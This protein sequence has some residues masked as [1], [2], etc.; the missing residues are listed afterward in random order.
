MKMCERNHAA[1]R[2]AVF[3]CSAPAYQRI[4]VQSAGCRIGA[5]GSRLG[6][7]PVCARHMRLVVWW[8]ALSDG[9]KAAFGAGDYAG[10]DVGSLRSALGR[11]PFAVHRHSNGTARRVPD[12]PD[13]DG[14]QRWLTA[15]QP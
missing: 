8:N 15:G 11:G 7:Q 12:S 6:S 5:L 1:G 2:C 13:L 3:E 10:V 4:D 14:F 9:D